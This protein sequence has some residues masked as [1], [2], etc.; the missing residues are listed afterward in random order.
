MLVYSM[1]PSAFAQ[2][3]AHRE[4]VMRAGAITDVPETAQSKCVE[5][6]VTSTYST[7][8]H[9]RQLLMTLDVEALHK[10]P[11]TKDGMMIWGIV[12]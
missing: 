7:L 2:I 12:G 1:A 10:T 4:P 6:S 5:G 8:R 3:L 11:T 9:T